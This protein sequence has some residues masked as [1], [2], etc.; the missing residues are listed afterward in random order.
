MTLNKR[1]WNFLS[2]VSGNVGTIFAIALLPVMLSVGAAI[3][4]SRASNLHSKVGHATDAALLAAVSNVVNNVDLE[5]IAAVN[6]ALKKEFKSFFLVNM[7]TADSYEYKGFTINFDPVTKGVDV[8]VDVDYKTAV[9]GI[10]GDHSWDSGVQ[11]ATSMQ[12]RVAAVSIFLVLDRSGSMILD[13][14]DGDGGT[15]MQSLQTAVLEMISDVEATDPKRQFTRMGSVS[16]NHLLG[17][18]QPIKWN[19]DKVKRFVGSMVATGGTDSSI[20]IEEAYR[21]LKK[22][23]EITT[24]K[25]KNGQEPELVLVFMT[26]GDNNTLERDVATKRTCDKARK[27]GMVI[28]SIAFLAPTKGQ[29]L[30][31]YCAS[32]SAHYFE[33]ENTDELIA[34]FKSIGGDASEKLLLE[35]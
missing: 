20:A 25:K 18:L 26:D 35:K 19:L 4:Y 2:H 28:Y 5:D 29:E 34:S 23:S 21:L 11:A 16:Y 6:A 27:Y 30:L 3:D 12:G 22:K 7:Q 33:P 9:F 8:D 15:K 1:V 17:T 14:G 31:E 13:N 32:S 10:V 24:H